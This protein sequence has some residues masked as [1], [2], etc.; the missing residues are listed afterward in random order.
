MFASSLTSSWT[1][2]AV[3]KKLLITG[4]GGFIGSR[5]SSFLTDK[6]Y[7]VIKYTGDINDVAALENCFR[8]V[9][10]AVHLAAKCDKVCA[11]RE[12]D[13]FIS[14]NVL[15][16]MNVIDLCLKYNCR[17]IHFSSISAKTHGDMYGLSKAFAEEIVK[18]YA[19]NRGLPAVIIRPSGV[20]DENKNDRLGKPMNFSKGQHYPIAYLVKD[21]ER[22]IQNH[23]FSSKCETFTPKLFFDYY[24]LYWLKRIRN[25]MNR[26]ISRLKPNPDNYDR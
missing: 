10:V 21:V 20:Y 25:K 22:I 5:L 1:P 15:G 9:D 14:V 2:M 12:K 6:G 3:N 4:A 8:N 26:S 17:L 23:N 19:K 18:F 11:R 24:V 13:S 7:E 16:T